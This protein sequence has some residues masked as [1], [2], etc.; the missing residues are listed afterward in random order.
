MAISLTSAVR[1]PSVQH[2][3]LPGPLLIGKVF[4]LGQRIYMAVNIQCGIIGNFFLCGYGFKELIFDRIRLPK[5]N[6][7]SGDASLIRRVKIAAFNFL[8]SI[9]QKETSIAEKIKYALHGSLFAASGV[10]GTTA[11]LHRLGMIDIGPALPWVD[12]FGTCAF[13][14]ANIVN[15][16]LNIRSY[17]EA[18]KAPVHLSEWALS[19]KKSAIIGMISNLGYILMS[20]FTLAGGPFAITMLLGCVAVLTGCL[21]ILYDF[22][23]LNRSRTLNG[24]H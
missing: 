12:I 8:E 20:A 21:K 22:I 2:V 17:I 19:K 10:L 18:S 13:M 7:A 3:C 14:L 4:D 9:Q 23:L 16:D 6:L 5:E 24:T 11:G 1:I 15:L